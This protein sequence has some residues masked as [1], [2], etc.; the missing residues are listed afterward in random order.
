MPTTAPGSKVGTLV[1]PD[2]S[3]TRPRSPLDTTAQAGPVLPADDSVPV[4]VGV[5]IFGTIIVFGLIMGARN[6]NR[7]PAR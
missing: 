4:R 1:D 3:L 2:P 7:R 6:L 5:A